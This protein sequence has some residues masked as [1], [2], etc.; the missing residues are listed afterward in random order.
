MTIAAK[1]YP[2]TIPASGS[3]RLPVTGTMFKVLSSTNTFRVICNTVGAIG[4]IQPGQGIRQDS[5]EPPFTDLVFED[6]SGAANNL[7]VLVADDSFI[8]DRISGEVSVVD[9][10][11]AR[12]LAG[13]AFQMPLT[14]AALAANYTAV[15]IDNSAGTKNVI[16]KAYRCAL[17]VAGFMNV[18][19]GGTKPATL[20]GALP[21]KVWDGGAFG[22]G[23]AVGRT[24]QNAADFTA[25]GSR[26]DVLNLPASQTVPIILQ[27]PIVLRP[28]AY[29][30]FQPASQNV[31]ISVTIEGYEEA[32]P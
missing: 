11:K 4:A 30:I 22:G 29:M 25:T 9:G 32:V 6:T 27:E 21:L 28:G 16:I 13:Q 2:I 8:D 26:L 31:G 5:K 10:G 14:G 23:V 18:N 19:M 24:G 7:Q 1:I 12:S 17:T 15:A 20:G 3:F